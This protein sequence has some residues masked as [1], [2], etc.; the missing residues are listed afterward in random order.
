MP[1]TWLKSPSYQCFWATWRPRKKAISEKQRPLLKLKKGGRETDDGKS[2][3]FLDN[4]RLPGEKNMKK[5]K[6]FTLRSY[7]SGYCNHRSMS[8]FHGGTL[9]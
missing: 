7:F 3:K 2:H 1:G 4:Q 6:T 8:G 5:D 9:T